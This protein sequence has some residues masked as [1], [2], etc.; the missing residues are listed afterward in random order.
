MIQI[1][2]ISYNLTWAIRHEVMYPE[3]NLDFVKL[4]NDT[5][6]THFG[7]YYNQKL[8]GIVSLFN[9]GDI[10]QL[11]KLAILQEAQGFGLGKNLMNHVIEYCQI[12]KAAKLWCNARVNVKE[13]YFLLGFKE[14]E[15]KFFKDG[16]DFIIMNLDL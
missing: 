8:T 15:T 6:G 7:L 13:F 10:Y 5:E 3:K 9:D 2:Q 11:R 14:T 1:E 16:Y 12:Q 4:E